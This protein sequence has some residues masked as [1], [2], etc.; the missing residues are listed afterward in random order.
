MIKKEEKT[1]RFAT[2]T[3]AAAT[4]V[5][6]FGDV[7]ISFPAPYSLEKYTEILQWNQGYLVVM[8]KYQHNGVP[9]EEY[10]DLIPILRQRGIEPERFLAPIEEVRIEGQEM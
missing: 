5:F 1:L 3:A 6:I 7:S 9:E 2:L 8:A 10:I 4:T